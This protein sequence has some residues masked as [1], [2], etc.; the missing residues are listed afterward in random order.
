MGSI[1]RRLSEIEKRLHVSREGP[2]KLYVNCSPDDWNDEP[3]GRTPE[4]KGYVVLSSEEAAEL[5]YIDL[6]AHVT[7]IVGHVPGSLEIKM[8]LTNDPDDDLGE[9]RG[10]R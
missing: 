5:G 10:W 8:R 7:P 1:A 4:Q 3:D 6:P 9:T 2:F